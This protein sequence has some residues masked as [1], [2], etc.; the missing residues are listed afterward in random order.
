MNSLF[1]YLASPIFSWTAACF[2][3]AAVAIFCVKRVQERRRRNQFR[4]EAC[5]DNRPQ[6]S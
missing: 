2:L 5:E 6:N 3:T 4:G 1:S